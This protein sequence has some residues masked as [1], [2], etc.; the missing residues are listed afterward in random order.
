[1]QMLSDFDG[2]PVDVLQTVCVSCGEKRQFLFDISSFHGVEIT[3]QRIAIAQFV[4][5]VDDE[6]LKRRLMS[7]R[8]LACLD[9]TPVHRWPFCP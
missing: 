5:Q 7:N 3:E 9:V 2:T 8:S 6:N 1:M 4:Q